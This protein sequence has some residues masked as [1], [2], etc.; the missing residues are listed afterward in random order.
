[1][2]PTLDQKLIAN[3]PSGNLVEWRTDAE[4][5]RLLRHYTDHPARITTAETMLS[6]VW[7]VGVI[8]GRIVRHEEA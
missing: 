4:T 6:F 3:D 8:S 7:H 2:K 5:L 1:M